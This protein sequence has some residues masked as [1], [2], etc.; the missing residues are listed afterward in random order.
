MF[1]SSPPDV[2]CPHRKS[3]HFGNSFPS[4]GTS[5]NFVIEYYID[6]KND[7]TLL[8]EPGQKISKLNIG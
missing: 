3:P 2:R 5:R 6:S 8:C 7:K 4:N 1:C